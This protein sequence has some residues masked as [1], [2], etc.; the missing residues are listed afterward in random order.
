MRRARWATALAAVA[1]VFVCPALVRDASAANDDDEPAHLDAARSIQCL[2]DGDGRIWR[3]QCTDEDDPNSK[4]KVCLYA[5][6]SELDADGNWTRPLERA[7]SCVAEGTFDQDGLRAKGFTLIPA[8]P[9]APRGWM[10][11]RRG[12][13]FQ[14]TFDLH[15][16]LYAGVSWAPLLHDAGGEDGAYDR[17]ALD[18][19]LLEFE[20]TTGSQ[21][22]GYRHRLRLVQGEVQL[23]PFG[24]DAVLVHY[25]F[26]R[27]SQI[28]LV[29]FTTFFG[30]P[31]R[32]DIG[33]HVGAWVELGHLEVDEV[34][35]D[36]S[37]SLWRYMTVH[38][39]WDVWRS[40]DMSSFVRLRGGAGVER[41]YVDPMAGGMDRDAI[42]PAGAVD[43]DL[44]LDGDGFHHITF[45]GQVERPQYLGEAADVRKSARRAQMRLAYEVIMVAVNDQPV[46]LRVASEAEYRDDVPGVDA[47]WDLR[48]TAGVRLSLWA[49]A[50]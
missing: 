44:T 16:R 38:A 6:N 19:G 21:K 27:R 49:P 45:V 3:V 37:E 14:I 35:P 47:G 8:I 4:A 11:D 2:T 36:R 26:S 17:A 12:R 34:A 40:R 24:A 25:D 42:S 5:P 7:R 13:V 32:Y 28:P 9:D 50:R 10:R 41:A 29:R 31:R 20:H 46:T 43:V 15:K 22:S 1:T 18:F 30:K 39:T 23:A 33:A 48:A